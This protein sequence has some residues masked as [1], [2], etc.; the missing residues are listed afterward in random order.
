MA[1]DQV[2]CLTC[3]PEGCECG[4]KRTKDINVNGELMEQRE[5]IQCD[6]G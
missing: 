2:A 5:C 6:P 4:E 3:P 1:E